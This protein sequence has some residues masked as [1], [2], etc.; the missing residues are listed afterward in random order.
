MKKPQAQEFQYP[1]RH[2]LLTGARLPHLDHVDWQKAPRT[3]KLYRGCEQIALEYEQLEPPRDMHDNTMTCQQLGQLLSDVYG[4]TRQ[5][6]T[7]GEI[8]VA[9]T[10]P[11]PSY[12]PNGQAKRRAALRRPVPSGGA[13][14]PCELYLL[15]GQGQALPP[16][17]YHYDAP[18]HALD[19][20]RKGDYHAYLHDCMARPEHLSSI[21]ILLSCLFWKNGYKYGEFSYRL[22]SLDIGAVIAQSLIVAGRYYLP[23]M[24]HYQFLDQAMNQLLGLDDLHESVYAAITLG[25]RGERVQ[26]V[27]EQPFCVPL[28]QIALQAE[29]LADPSTS[30]S[31]WPLLN[32]LHRKSFMQ[33]VNAF[34][35]YQGVPAISPPEALTSTC[36][37]LAATPPDLLPGLYKR[38]SAQNYFRP[39]TITESQL[40]ALLAA[41]VQGYASDLDEQHSI[42]Q[43]IL[44]Y[45]II[46]AVEGIA[47]G[48]YLYQPDKQALSLIYAGDVRTELQNIQ[49]NMASVKMFHMSAC[50]FLVG[51]YE[52]G[53]Q[54][55]G[56]RWYR[57]QNMEAGIGV[58]RLSLAA[59][60][61]NLGCRV[62]LGYYVHL[63]NTLLR[64]PAE[65]TSLVEIM[66]ASE[67]T[68]RS[69]E[70]PL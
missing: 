38:H 52:Y 31:Q 9:S 2:Y 17:I 55:Y 62:N 3:F 56:D 24:V 49:G 48:I 51:N 11:S 8:A 43:H 61:L 28:K 39:G 65:F 18:H 20:L 34:R 21:T 47:P 16:G 26:E 29:P 45:C 68:G 14:Y 7:S 57:M 25:Q 5:L 23:A 10:T 54:V 1:G 37:P 46:N 6:R 70:Q 50:L 33:S 32:E 13:L 30:I 58:Q 19:I 63:A 35:M 59:A 44:F 69:Y 36:H 27:I 4:F 60:T 66:I 22:Q 53:F 12:S 41:G 67:Y 15:I 64:L 42:L 40:A